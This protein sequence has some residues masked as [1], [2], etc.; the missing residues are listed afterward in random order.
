MVIGTD[1]C[2]YACGNYVC[3]MGMVS[4][5]SCTWVWVNEQVSARVAYRCVIGIAQPGV[6]T[7]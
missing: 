5:P 7:C 2:V 6:L 3:A 1:K 4:V